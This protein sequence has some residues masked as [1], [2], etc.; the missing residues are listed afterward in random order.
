MVLKNPKNIPIIMYF[1]I[2]ILFA[3]QT[4]ATESPWYLGAD[5][6][7]GYYSNGSNQEST[8]S[9]RHRLAGGIRLGY[10]F[11]EYLALEG[12]YQ[13]LGQ[14]YANYQNG[15]IEAKFHQGLIATKLRYGITDNLYPYVKI[16]GAAWFG[17]E[18]GLVNETANGFSPVLGAGLAIQ[19]TD[20]LSLQAEYQLTQS[21][22]DDSI[23]HADHHLSTV[24]LSYS[25]GKSTTSV[26]IVHEKIVEVIIEKPIIVETVIIPEH[27][28][29]AL[30]AHNSSILSNYQL[31]DN[32]LNQLR[33]YP[34]SQV[35]VIGHTDSTGSRKYNQWMSE[36]R[37]KSVANYFS[38]NG[39]DARRINTLGKGEDNPIAN[40][41]TLSGRAMNRRVEMTIASMEILHEPSN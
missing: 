4:N 9:E 26:P 5:L 25:F 35:M 13:Y 41:N 8:K 37:A 14:P 33:E 23:G 18:K 2:P 10:Q 27:S 7:L 31:L 17:Q 30:F 1:T 36:R 12:G 40:N 29:Q 24:G 21:L 32:T 15:K 39:I 28:S 34:Q 22:G 11:T 6:G 19:L 20:N 38:S 3:S 16:G